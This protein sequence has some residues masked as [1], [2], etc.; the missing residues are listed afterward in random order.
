MKADIA[1]W[2]LK[3]ANL[4]CLREHKYEVAVLPV[5]AIEAHNHH[6][7]EGI[8]VIHTEYVAQTS[9]RKAWELCRSVICLPAVP[10]GVDSN[11]LAFPL[12]IHV[13]QKTLDA[14]LTEI[15]QSLRQHGI[16]K[17]VIVNGHGGNEFRPLVRQL[18]YDTD[19]HVFVCNWWKVGADVVSKMF[20]K[21]DDHGGAFETSVALEICPQL[22]DVQKAGDGRVP[23]FRFEA[24]QKGWVGTS[25]DFSKLN[26]H[27]AISSDVAPD[28]EKGRQ[29]LSLVCDRIS[30]FL[31]E[32]AQSEIDASFPMQRQ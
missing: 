14:Y 24:L 25:R 7:P 4:A 20:G 17:V 22:L 30:S 26:D 12:T 9:C 13:S 15:V 16:R 27:C 8:D 6:L 11:L 31:V 18:Q 28:V 5:G 3:R 10:F 19:V 1:A 2:D 29:Y 23:P 21:G 32:L